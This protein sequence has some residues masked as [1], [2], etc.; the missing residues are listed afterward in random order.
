MTTDLSV[1]CLRDARPSQAEHHHR[2]GTGPVGKGM[3]GTHEH[4]PTVPL[5]R[6][7][8]EA[9]HRQ[10]FSF[11]VNGAFYAGKERDGGEWRSPVKRSDRK[12]T[13]LWSEEKLRLVWHEVED[14]AAGLLRVQCEIAWVLRERFGYKERWYVHVA[15]LLSLDADRRVDWRRVYERCQMWEL[16]ELKL[17]GERWASAQ[18]VGV[19]ALKRIAKADD[20]ERAFN[21]AVD[22]R[23]GGMS[24]TA[25]AERL[26]DQAETVE[27]T[28]SVCGNIHRRHWRKEA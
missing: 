28:C 4:L 13:R 14:A 24:A 22:A 21:D 8:H 26:S 2:E 20:P 15:D 3:G 23:L 25:V 18:L 12:E 5:C 9:V 10:E 7:C 19:K 17:G 11:S 27:C 1:P 16:V 6:A